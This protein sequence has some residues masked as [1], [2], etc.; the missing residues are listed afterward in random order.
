MI[1]PDEESGIARFAA[2][3]KKGSPWR[4][5]GP[6][7]LAWRKLGVVKGYQYDRG[8]KL[9]NWIAGN[10]GSVAAVSGNAPLEAL[11]CKLLQGEVDVVIDD[12]SAFHFAAD[13]RK[14]DDRF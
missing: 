8:G 9:D 7:S 5:T 10:P 11:Q 14:L 3:V 1:V 2:F 13:G 4:Y 6:E 12:V